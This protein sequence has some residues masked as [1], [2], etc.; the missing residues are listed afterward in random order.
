MTL[1]LIDLSSLAYPI[2]HQNQT[3]PDPTAT[4]TQTLAR[5]RAIA[6]GQP[7]VAICCDSKRSLRREADPTYKANR[8]E[9]DANL[10]HQI[11]VICDALRADGFP[12]WV[13]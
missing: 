7:H 9:R 1:L 3:N 13:L 10:L 11:A 4:V 6:S 8:P 2:W 5:I 12:V